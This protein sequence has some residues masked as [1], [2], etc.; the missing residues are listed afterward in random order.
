MDRIFLKTVLYVVASGA[1]LLLAN[2]AYAE[3]IHGISFSTSNVSNVKI[4]GLHANAGGSE[5]T[6]V[7]NGIVDKI[8]SIGY[9]YKYSE[10]ASSPW[11]LDFGL[12]YNRTT[13]PSVNAILK[14]TVSGG[15]A[16]VAQPP[17]SMTY[18]EVYLGGIY[19]LQSI[20]LPI[21][22]GAGV[23]YIKGKAYKT[24]YDANNASIYGL[25]G[26]S[27]L[28]GQKVSLK[29][30]FDYANYSIELERGQYKVHVQ[31]YRS[32]NITG[33]DINYDSTTLRAIYKF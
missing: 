26:S 33:A 5:L 3:T 15:T 2:S 17:A 32:F 19:H 13:M 29:A 1:T 25:S 24:S 30:G 6:T 28:E 21:Y 22:L 16:T 10:K 11:Q 14:G 31:Q 20:D 18:G 27:A 12:N 9:D 23:S 8:N 4:A 7:D